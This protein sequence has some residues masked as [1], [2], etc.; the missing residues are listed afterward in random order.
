[1]TYVAIEADMAEGKAVPTEG[2]KLL[3]RER[4]LITLLPEAR[5]RTDWQAVE[6]SVGALRRLKLDSS[7]WQHEAPAEWDRA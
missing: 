3:E 2:T 7:V 4:T 1:M 5:H 6:A